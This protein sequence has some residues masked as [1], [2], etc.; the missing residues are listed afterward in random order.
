MDKGICDKGIIWNAS[1]CECECD[2]SWDVV[3][4]LDYNNCK[5]RQILVDKLV[6]E[7]NENIDEKNY[8]QIKSL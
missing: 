8:I 6:E 2:E 7:C 3:E 5:C 1:N 4:C